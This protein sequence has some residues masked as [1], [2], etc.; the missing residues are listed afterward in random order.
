MLSLPFCI[1][2]SIGNQPE[3]KFDQ[4]K[5]RVVYSNLRSTVLE[6][7]EKSLTRSDDT[8][9]AV[10]ETIK[11]PYLAKEEKEVKSDITP[12]QLTVYD[13]ASILDL[14]QANFAP[15]VRGTLAK[16]STNYL[17]L[18]GGGMLKEG[19]S[20]PVQIPQIEDQSF[21]ITILEITTRGYTMKMNDVIQGVTFEK[22]SGAIKESPK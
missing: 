7:A 14:I 18:N 11:N 22:S 15:Q 19:D 8:V 4:A 10:L 1:L 13:D 5:D 16:G 6:A 9:I 21:N 20:F 12:K 2:A 17:Q 3:I